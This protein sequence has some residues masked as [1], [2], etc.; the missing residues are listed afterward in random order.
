MM[1]VDLGTM[2]RCTSEP[3][4]S[5]TVWGPGYL[6]FPEVEAQGWLV[7]YVRGKPLSICLEMLVP[8]LEDTNTVDREFGEIETPRRG[9][10]PGAGYHLM[11]GIT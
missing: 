1:G 5:V 4:A 8:N 7:T 11:L 2:W 6:S 9:S 3:S 10:V